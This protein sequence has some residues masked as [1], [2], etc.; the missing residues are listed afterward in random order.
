MIL[1]YAAILDP[2]YKLQFIWYCFNDLDEETTELKFKNMKD[3]FYKLFE[4]YMKDTPQ[5]N[6]DNAPKS[7]DDD[8]VVSYTTSNISILFH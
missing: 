1:S 5:V 8:L 3:K 6:L 2:R 7:V 4:E